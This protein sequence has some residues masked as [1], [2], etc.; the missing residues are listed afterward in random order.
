MYIVEFMVRVYDAKS[1]RY[2]LFLFVVFIKLQHNRS[3]RCH[4]KSARLRTHR[5]SAKRVYKMVPSLSS[6]VQSFL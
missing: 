3:F 1:V 2:V 4:L 5:F 6:R